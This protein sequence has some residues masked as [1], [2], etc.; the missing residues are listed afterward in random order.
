MGDSRFPLVQDLNRRDPEAVVR[1]YEG[2]Q[3]PASEA[4]L[5]EYVK[6]LG[7]LDRLDGS[8]LIRTLQQGAPASPACR[9]YFCS[10]LPPY[11]NR[12]KSP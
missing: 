11:H 1:Q 3:V 2:G 5:A 12:A 10:R 6:A 4:T 9:T 7:K 8:A